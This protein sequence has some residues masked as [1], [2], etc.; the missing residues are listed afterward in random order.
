MN[1]CTT[2]A[3]T[4]TTTTQNKQLKNSDISKIR[5]DEIYILCHS[6]RI[7]GQLPAPVANGGGD[8]F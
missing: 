6:L 1:T 2:T 4:T 7:H 8:S 5:P 3:T